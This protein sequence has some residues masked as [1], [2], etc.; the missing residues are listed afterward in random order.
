MTLKKILN[1]LMPY[2]AFAVFLIVNAIAQHD[3][4]SF[5][6]YG[7]VIIA[8][9]VGDILSYTDLP[10]P[11]LSKAVYSGDVVTAIATRCNSSNSILTYQT[12]RILKK[13]NSP[14]A[15]VVLPSVAISA[16]PGCSP[17]STKANVVPSDTLP[18][19]YRF[20]GVAIL[21]GLMVDHEVG[22]NTDVFEVVARPKKEKP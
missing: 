22:W 3:I 18:G 12:S 9:I 20:S 16:K 6:V 7:F 21:K 19:F 5:Y 4:S 2:L 1:F 8:M 13:E 14:Q 11:T 17:V 10:F 15:D